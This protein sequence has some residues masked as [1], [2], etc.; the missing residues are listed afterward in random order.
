MRFLM[1]ND[2][3][4]QFIVDEV[5]IRKIPRITLIKWKCVQNRNVFFWFDPILV[6]RR[7]FWNFMRPKK[8]KKFDYR[9]FALKK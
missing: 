3:A 5:S 8:V 1:M 9:K 6:L 2:T 7:A 4:L